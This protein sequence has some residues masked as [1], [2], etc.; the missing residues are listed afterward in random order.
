MYRKLLGGLASTSLIA[1]LVT[2]GAVASGVGTATP[3]LGAGVAVNLGTVD[4]SISDNYGTD[5]NGNGEVTENNCLTYA[6]I[7]PSATSTAWVVPPDE[8]RAGHGTTGWDCPGALSTDTQSVVGFM[9]TATGTVQTGTSFLLGQITHYNQ[10]ISVNSQY[11]KGNVNLRL[12][13]PGKT[14]VFPYLLNETP[15]IQEP[16]TNPLNDDILNITSQISSVITVGD[17]QYRL[18]ADGFIQG[19]DA[20]EN[21]KCKA[22]P[23]VGATVDNEFVTTETQTTKGCL[24]GTLTQVRTLKVVKEVKWDSAVTAP[25][26]IPEFSFDSTS[27]LEGSPWQAGSFKL[28][29]PA[30][31]GGTDEFPPAPS[32]GNQLLAT[33]ETVTLTEAAPGEDWE[34][35]AIQCSDSAG[36]VGTVDV[37]GRMATLADVPEVTAEAQ[38]PITCEFTNTYT[39]SQLTLAKDWGANAVTGD[40]ADL[41]IEGGITD[42]ATVTSTA[43]VDGTK[44]STDAKWGSAITLSE[45]FSKGNTNTYS[46]SLKCVKSG[47][48]EEVGGSADG[49]FDM[50]KYAVTCTYSNEGKALNPAIKIVKNASATEVLADST[51]VYSYDVTNAGDTPLSDVKVSD[52]KCSPVTYKSGDDGDF[53]LQLGEVWKYEC[54]KALSATETNTATATGMDPLGKTVESKATATVTVTPKPT[55]TPTVSPEVVKRICPIDPKLHTP[56]AKKVGNRV[57]T[58][59][60]TTKKSSCVL[61]KPVVLC[62][63]VSANAAG[64]TAFCDTKVSKKG[65]ITVKTKGYD[66][67]KVTAVVRSKPKPGFFDRWK[68]NT[69]RKSWTLR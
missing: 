64:E 50:P 9:P 36:S 26:G 8:A 39:R 30:S 16:S 61:L 68:A 15:N 25:T 43:P 1:G 52:D 13:G 44:V 2:V 24:Y 32:E 7:S 46:K 6:P 12:G 33:G 3:A 10:P 49:T 28:T 14:F 18:V 48:S 19:A 57:M 23:P 38:L 5:Q 31:N 17:F 35:T 66:A 37:D 69:W 58:D 41:T 34:L 27:S 29:P 42:P 45:D 62:R 51:V 60:I 65:R 56:Q 59:K 67:V 47:T 63:P 20:F 55:P 21:G 54:S 22:A 40:K 11:F 4:A 53:V